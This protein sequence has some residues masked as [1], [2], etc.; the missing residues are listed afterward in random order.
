MLTPPGPRETTI[1]RPP[2]TE[3][4]YKNEHEINVL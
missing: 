2:I 3:R 1:R 4:V